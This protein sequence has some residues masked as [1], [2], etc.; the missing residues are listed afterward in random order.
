MTDETQTGI[1]GLT[2]ESEEVHL[3]IR[4]LIGSHLCLVANSGGGKSGLIRRLLETTH[5]RVQHIVLDG[6]DEFYTLRERFDYVIAG[7]DGGD[8]PATLKTAEDLAIGALTHGFSLIAQ[9]NDLGASGAPD[10]I[11]RFLTAMVHAPRALWHPVL[12]VVDELQRF[13]PRQGYSGATEGIR[14]LLAQGRKRGFTAIG[15]GTKLTDIDP[16]IRGGFNN[17]LLGR[18]G[19]TIDRN[20]A[21]EQL[22]FTPKEGRDKLRAMPIRMFW[23]FGPA[24]SAEPILFRVAD[25]ETTPVRP[26]DAKIPTPPAP[27]ALRDILSA[28]AKPEPEPEAEAE[29][30]AGQTIVMSDPNP[31][32]VEEI[33]VLQGQIAGLESIAAARL[34]AVRALRSE[35]DGTL[36]DVRGRLESLEEVAVDVVVSLPAPGDKTL[37]EGGGF[38]NAAGTH[39][40]I[41]PRPGI[42]RPRQ[43]VAAPPPPPPAVPV[44]PNL[45]LSK[46]ATDFIAMLDSIA[47][48]KVTFPQLAAMIGGKASGGTYNTACRD[49]RASGR[50]RECGG[51]FVQ[52]T[53]PVRRGMSREQAADLW[54]GVL[55]RLGG[56]ASAMF[57]ALLAAG[58]P[59]TKDEIAEAVGIVARGGNWTQN[60]GH[61]RKNGLVEEISE[62]LWAP[63]AKLPGER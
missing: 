4:A 42:D 51:G 27:D 43:P 46:K 9:L 30:E 26:G 29:G 33:Q 18:T 15:A 63:P 57:D 37:A 48:A 59:M 60:W 8:C 20:A 21:A 3:D 32:L 17:W 38:E 55:T 31:A 6:E 24:I 19:Q 10:F 41:T 11:G 25:V 40:S 45:K 2:S 34:E 35:I 1:L 62:N 22:G 23:G 36:S 5:G 47:P 49:A 39:V 61:L 12:V 16:S 44:D 54:R 58:N 7:G 14:A 56:K 50:L 28:L 53:Q 13:A 52:S